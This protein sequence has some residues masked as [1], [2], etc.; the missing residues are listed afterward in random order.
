[1]GELGEP[2]LSVNKDHKAGGAR[3]ARQTS[4]V[5]NSLLGAMAAAVDMED[6]R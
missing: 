2:H 6:V 1:M 3:R 5:D 4:D